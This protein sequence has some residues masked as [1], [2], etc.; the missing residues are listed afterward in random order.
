MPHKD[1]HIDAAIRLLREHG[2][3]APPERTVRVEPLRPGANARYQSRTGRI[4]VNSLGDPYRAAQAGDLRELAAVLSHE[5][6]HAIY[7]GDEVAAYAQSVAALRA[8]GADPSLIADKLAQ[9]TEWAEYYGEQRAFN[10]HQDARQRQVWDRRMR[11]RQ[12]ALRR[13]IDADY[14]A[15]ERRFAGEEL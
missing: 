10:E 7:G 3:L 8:L 1:R 15:A 6:H 13:R 12:A 4:T 5:A 2:L 9:R 11:E 14:A